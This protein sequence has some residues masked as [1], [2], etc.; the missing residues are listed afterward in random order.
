MGKGWEEGRNRRGRKGKRD[1]GTGGKG[2]REGGKVK[3]MGKG[4][5]GGAFR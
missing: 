4:R 3:R 1:V 5:A 2:K